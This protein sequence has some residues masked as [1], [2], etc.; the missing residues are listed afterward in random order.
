[1]SLGFTMRYKP[2]VKTSDILKTSD[3]Y[4]L[5]VNSTY[6]CERL[7]PNLKNKG[8]IANIRSSSTTCVKVIK[9]FLSVYSL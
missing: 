3:V 6:L 9:L 2:N 8:C 5:L 7:L 1:M 4:K